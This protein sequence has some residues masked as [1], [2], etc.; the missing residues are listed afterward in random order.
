MT[1]IITGAT[2]TNGLQVVRQTLE[3]GA[4]VRAFVRDREEARK[5]L[6]SE[7]EI[8][9][10]DFARKDSVRQA[11]QGV[12]RVFLLAAVHPRMGEFEEA[13]I[14]A[15]REAKVHHLVQF[16]AIGA[17]PGSKAF[18]GRVHGRAEVALVQSGLAYTILQ[19]SFFMQNLF[20]S[21]E[22][23]K[24]DRA[25]YNAA[26]AGA[27]AHV[28][29]ADIAAVAATALTEPIDQHAGEIYIVTGPE[30]LTYEEIAAKLSKVLGR[31]IRHQSLPDAVYKENMLKL[32]MPDW[33]AQAILELD[34]R[35][36][37]GEFSNATDV[38][39][40]VAK[41]PPVSFDQFAR[42]NRAAFQ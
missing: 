41:K 5:L 30:R 7:A 9:E 14:D 34:L 20:W 25:I 42:E 31:T 39:E 29:A 36:W 8:F 15:A 23:I 21:A 10:G 38:V 22:T 40:R 18:F 2:G 35:C 11:L 13:F 12:E 3:K 33:Q 19:P 32:G 4:R 6:P 17:H 28:D 1:I 16:S 27:A 24:R 26:G 37:H